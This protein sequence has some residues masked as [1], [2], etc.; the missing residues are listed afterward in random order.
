MTNM[1][2]IYIIESNNTG[3]VRKL[4]SLSTAP[5]VYKKFY[6]DGSSNPEA[7]LIAEGLPTTTKSM[8]DLYSDFTTRVASVSIP[9]LKSDTIEYSF[10]NQRYIVPGYKLQHDFNSALTFEMDNGLEYMRLFNR[11]AGLANRYITSNGDTTQPENSEKDLGYRPSR[12]H[13]ENQKYSILVKILPGNMFYNKDDTLK[14]Y[15]IFEDVLFTG[16]GDVSFNQSNSD[17]VTTT[18][19]F[20]YKNLAIG[21]FPDST[22]LLSADET[23]RIKHTE[24]IG[25]MPALQQSWVMNDNLKT[26]ATAAY[27]TINK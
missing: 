9:D 6:T 13:N 3:E 2:D 12:V 8:L 22:N 17:L 27:T 7:K 11:M 18:F 23:N 5:K 24:A 20:I 21:E 4:L 15:F 25:Y 19:T 16:G 1:Y 14:R 10:L 26:D